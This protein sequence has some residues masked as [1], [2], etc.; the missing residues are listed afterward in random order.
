MKTTYTIAKLINNN[1]V[2]ST[3]EEGKEVILFGKAIGFG[4]KRGDTVEASQVLKVFESIDDRSRTYLVNLVEDIEP[5]YV[6]LAARIVEIFETGLEVKI[7]AMMT[8]SL[9]DHLFNAVRN[10]REGFELSLDML[11]VIK[12]MYPT[13]FVLAREGL[14]I[15]ARETG[16][17]LNESEAG[18]IVLHYLNTQGDTFREDA[19]F[20]LLFQERIIDEVEKFLG[21]PLDRASFYYNRFLTH[22]SFLAARLHDG[23]TFS[24]ENA[25]L[26]DVL[27]EKYPELKPCMEQLAEILKQEFSVKIDEEEKAYLAIHINNMILALRRRRK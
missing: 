22:L 2:F 21:F 9:S 16:V 12:N 18:F 26:Y 17:A 5:L 10:K 15:V 23:E 7:S 11:P 1:V 6:D 20:R 14:A 25:D 19:K 3:N 13:E 27:M 4:K 8:I 24:N